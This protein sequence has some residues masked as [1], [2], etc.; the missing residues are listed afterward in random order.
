MSLTDSSVSEEKGE[1]KA[2]VIGAG[3][4]ERGIRTPEGLLTL[5]RFPGVRLKPLIHLSEP[6]H[7]SRAADAGPAIKRGA[8][9]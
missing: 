5:T 6:V 7:F 1:K 9:D 3:G 4:G 2:P 8:P